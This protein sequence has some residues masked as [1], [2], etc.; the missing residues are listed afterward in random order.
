MRI[1]FAGDRD[2]SIKVLKFILKSGVKPLSLLVSD[3]S[4]QTHARELIQMCSP[5]MNTD[6]IFEGSSFRK[7]KSI[8]M[9]QQ[10]SL[11]YIIS[12]H[13]PYIVSR[14]IL[15]VPKYGVV[16]LHP[17]Y[18]PYNRGWHTPTWA[19]IEDTPIGATLHF[20][21]EGVDTGDII[22]QRKMDIS[23]GDTA[24]SL[25]KKLKKL[26]FEV[27][28]DAWQ[29]LAH[30]ISNRIPQGLSVGTVHK[31]NDLFHDKIQKIDLNSFLKAENLIRQLRA[32]TT[33]DLNEA[34]YY[35][36]GKKRYRIQIKI[37]EEK[38]RSN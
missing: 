1:A 5:F 32:L 34:A 20:M 36:V 12:V 15:L 30:G 26:E 3:K 13:F 11:D 19:I 14:E 17:A 8:S 18:L 23:L 22:Y 37:T 27:F 35:N 33:N 4:R 38:T 2:I 10:L 25:Y 6:F 24:D 28:K 9:L 21:D 7:K 29:P 16:N 31:K